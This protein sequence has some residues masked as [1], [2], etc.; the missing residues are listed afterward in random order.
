MSIALGSRRVRELLQAN[1]EERQIKV[2]EARRTE[3]EISGVAAVDL[4]MKTAF[5]PQ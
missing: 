5:L 4:D 3:I 1:L 2:D